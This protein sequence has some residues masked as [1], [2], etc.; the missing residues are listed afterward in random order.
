[1]LQFNFGQFG[2]GLRR[3]SQRLRTDRLH[4]KI[5]LALGSMGLLIL[6]WTIVFSPSIALIKCERQSDYYSI[7]DLW[8]T[9]LVGIP[10]RH[11]RLDPLQGSQPFPR[12]GTS[13]WTNRV[14]LYGANGK[15]VAFT[16]FSSKT[17]EV[18]QVAQ[19]IN[20]FLGNND[21]PSFRFLQLVPCPV[22]LTIVL[23][24]ALLMSAGWIMLKIE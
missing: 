9:S 22:F 7:C 12:D 1:M 5:G 8:G 14:M 15:A 23:G 21:L 18:N 17:A 13:G 16:Q 19:K 3:V 11:I 24:S 20:Q 6:I 10:V 2:Q 4:Q